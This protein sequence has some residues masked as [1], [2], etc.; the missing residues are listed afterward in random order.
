MN[1]TQQ[2]MIDAQ[3][4]SQVSSQSAATAQQMAMDQKER[5]I[6]NEDFLNELRKLDL[7][8]DE[9]GWVEDRYPELF[10][11]IHA[12]SNRGDHWAKEA[13]LRMANKRERAIAEARP[14]RLLRTRPFMLAAMRGDDSPPVDAYLQDGIPGAADEWRAKIAR[15]DTTDSPIGSAKVRVI[16]GATDAAADQMALSR[17]AAGLDAVSTVKTDSTVRKQSEDET[18]ASRLGRVFE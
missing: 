10:A 9:Y 11:G 2:E 12:V 18:T 6:H 3:E 1:D 15:K 14:G 4:T 16:N 5:T 8:S 7:E 17:N 13:D